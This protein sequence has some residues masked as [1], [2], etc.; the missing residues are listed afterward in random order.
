MAR[1]A[2]RRRS[3]RRRVARGAGGK[4]VSR[5][6]RV[7]RRRRSRR[8][9]GN[10][11]GFI[12]VGRRWRKMTKY[13]RR[14]RRG[15][16]RG[17]I[18][19]FSFPKR[20]RRRRSSGRR[21]YAR[22]NPSVRSYRRRRY[23]RRN[24]GTRSMRLSSDPIGAIK[25][26]LM[27]A[28]SMDTLEALFHT[29][30]GFGG[31]AAGGRLL[32]KKVIPSFGE[33]AIGRVGTMTG[34]TVLGTALISMV[35]KNRA[36]TARFLAGGALATLWQVL[37]E[38]LP[39]SAKEFIPT[40]GA[41]PETEAFRKAIEKEVLRELRGGSMN[42]YLQPAGAEGISEYIQPAGVENTYLSPA[43][44]E[45]YLTA[46]DGDRA[47]DRATMGAFLTENETER[48]ELNPSGVGDPFDEFART[49]MPERF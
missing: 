22:R 5:K 34:L 49:S 12:K 26:A 37:S 48:V 41:P 29:G 24:P 23:A 42:E 39:E 19:G 7:V 45:T 27:E 17:Q 3:G 43:G 28:F 44:S 16:R 38:A 11:S 47:I 33:T 18:S 2:T 9:P 30:L 6:R 10:P 40:L 20:Y 36:F 1:S 8:N 14:R 31:V 46:V 35:T 32:Y 25:A 4:F 13:A 15:S 21:R